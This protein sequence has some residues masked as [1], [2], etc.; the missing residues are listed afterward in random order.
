[1]GLSGLNSHRKSYHFIQNSTCPNCNAKK[2]D[3]AHYLFQCPSYA[4]HRGEMVAG[5]SVILP[6][7]SN[8]LN[9]IHKASA[10]KELMNIVLYGRNFQDCDKIY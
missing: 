4:A 3:T 9:N 2:E 10:G 5:L 8:K 7:H 1:M 6:T